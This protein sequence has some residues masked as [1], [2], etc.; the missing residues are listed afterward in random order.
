MP[1]WISFSSL[2]PKSLPIELQFSSP[3]SP[4]IQVGT[5]VGDGR[6]PIRPGDTL[7]YYTPAGELAN[8]NSK[9]AKAS[10]VLGIVAVSLVPFFCCSIFGIVAM[11]GSLVCG[12]L[13]VKYARSAGVLAS[14]NNAVA[15]RVCGIIAIVASG[16]YIVVGIVLVVMMIG[17]ASSFPPPTTIP[18][19]NPV[20][21]PPPT[22]PQP[23]TVPS[24]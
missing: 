24:D 16:V 20:F 3:S 4:S 6:A 21:I 19:T 17:V 9:D 23:T 11:V 12:I 8:A 10:M 18:T 14:S 7:T 1:D 5:P 15:G 22:N 2:D 13:A